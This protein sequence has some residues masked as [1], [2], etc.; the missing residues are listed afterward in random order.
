MAIG[1]EEMFEGLVQLIDVFG[2]DVGQ[3]SIFGL[4]PN[5]LD[6]IEFG[7]VCRQPFDLEPW[8]TDLRKLPN[9]GT[10][11]RQTIADEDKR[12]AQVR[13][14]FLQEANKVGRSSV[15]VKEFVIQAQPGGPRCP[16]DCGQSRDSIVTIPRVLNR[17]VSFGG[18]HSPPQRLQQIAT[19]IEKNQASLPLE[20]LFLSAA[21]LRGASGRCHPRS[22]RA[23]A[24]PASADSNRVCEANEA[25]IPDGGPRQRVAGSCLERAGLSTRTERTPNSASPAT[26]NAPIRRVV[27]SRASAFCLDVV[28]HAVYSR[29]AR[30]SSID[31]PKRRSSQLPQPLPSMTFPARTAGPRSSDGLRA[32]RDFLMVSCQHSSGWSP[33]FH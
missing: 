14:D 13:M 1:F 17:C 31:A 18:P 27:E 26:T 8:S 23:P 29:V 30:H 33:I 6:G 16:R 15:V 9:G 24:V 32:L 19:F 10:M 22:V 11:R 2:D 28:S 20:A 12:T 3:F 4:V 5:V 21:S 7:S 25:R